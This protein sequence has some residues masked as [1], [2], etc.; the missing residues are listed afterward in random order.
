MRI[1]TIKPEFFKDESL[2]E[3]SAFHRL[4]FAGLW[5][6]AD[7]EG[8]L[9]DRPKFI[10]AEIFPYD[11]IDAEKILSD[12]HTAGFIIRYRADGKNFIFIKNFSKHQRPNSREAESAIPAY[13]ENTTD[14]NRYNLS[15]ARTRT[16][17]QD[18]EEG[19]GEG[20]RKGKGKEGE[21]DSHARKSSH[22]Q[23][24]PPEDF[25]QTLKENPAYKAIDVDRELS[26]MDAWLLTPKGKHKRKTKAFVVNWL[27]RIDV[28]ISGARA[29]PVLEDHEERAARIERKMKAEQLGGQNENL[30]N[31]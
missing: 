30:G 31:E 5:T 16:L 4:F 7:R 10:K 20:E 28:P 11:K 2:A 17:V 26:K 14:E 24:A 18:R 25:I 23:T 21:G 29:G 9:E 12:L 19:E 22:D 6:M 3:H 15:H 8:R 27:N 13:A 1:R